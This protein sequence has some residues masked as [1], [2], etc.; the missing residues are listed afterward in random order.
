MTIVNALRCWLFWP[1]TMKAQSSL[2]PSK[3][4]DKVKVREILEIQEGVPHKR[5]F[6]FECGERILKKI[7]RQPI[8]LRLSTK[9][10]TCMLLISIFVCTNPTQW[11]PLS[12]KAMIRCY[13]CVFERFAVKPAEWFIIHDEILPQNVMEAI[14][15]QLE[16][17]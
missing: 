14:K 16:F 3:E 12:E 10:E 17:H 7:G 1:D 13:D 8:L 11:R 5:K 4:A 9:H 6:F 15:L 2:P